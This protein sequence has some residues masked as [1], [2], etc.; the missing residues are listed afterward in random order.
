[1]AECWVDQ[2][3]GN[4]ANPGT[5]ALPWKLIPGQASANAFA[6]GTVGNP[7][8]INVK[9]GTTGSVR[10]LPTANYLLYRGYGIADNV[11][12]LT[13]PVANDPA[14]LVTERVVRT[15][16]V[17]EGMWKLVDLSTTTSMIALGNRIGVT[18]E[19]VYVEKPLATE[20]VS[21]G[22]SAS[23]GNSPTL[24]RSHI[25]GADGTGL[26]GYQPGFTVEHVKIENI[27]DDAILMTAN[28]TNGYRAG[29]TDRFSCIDVVEPGT[30]TGT[31][32][33]DALQTVPTTT[34]YES[35]LIIKRLHVYKSSAVKQ[36][37]QLND[38]TAGFLIDGFH[39]EAPNDTG[40]L[41]TDIA[42]IKGRLEI[43]NGYISGGGGGNAIFRLNQDTGVVTTAAAVIELRNITAI[44]TDISSFYTQGAAG[45]AATHDGAVTVE[46][47]TAI[48][49]N[50]SGLSYAAGISGH[51]GS[52]VT[53]GAGAS[54]TVRNNAML[55]TGTP[56]AVL[57]PSG[58]AG[59][60]LYP[61]KGNAALDAATYAIGGTSY[62]TLALFEAAHSQATGNSTVADTAAAKIESGRPLPTSP[63]IGAGTHTTYT[64]DAAGIQRP[65]PP[66][67][68][69]Y[70]LPTQR[71]VLD[72]DPAGW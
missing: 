14:Q 26:A 4:D 65:N 51:P 36:A 7:N 21:F 33:G 67:I 59:S 60:A 54:L 37:L 44:A 23:T 63:L 1:M 8:I 61:V 12:T 39:F 70:D 38:A 56:P 5:E 30:D 31:A 28:A 3:N 49:N 47:C 15:P 2:D 22:T 57:L 46:H 32:I 9:N 58:K 19:D 18:V 48:G 64:R 16:G 72:S 69:A 25:K 43:R 50:P 52:N 71:R 20:A 53:I 27:Q 42:H 10:L 35:G 6:G 34:R 55:L 41:S 45:S 62:A 17:H 24:R 66:S 11:L 40:T 13:L 29:Y 68:G